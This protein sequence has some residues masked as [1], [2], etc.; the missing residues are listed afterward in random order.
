M[1]G[2]PRECRERAA[3]CLEL[4]AEAVNDGIKQTFLRIA[5][6]WQLLAEEL[7]RARSVLDD[8]K[9]AIK[10]SVKKRRNTKPRLRKARKK[11]N[12]QA[13]VTQTKRANGREAWS[14]G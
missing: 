9:G 3:R 13:G 14:L 11:S 10:F 1:P 2:D 7:E 8:E 5:K 6:H 12:V 4:A